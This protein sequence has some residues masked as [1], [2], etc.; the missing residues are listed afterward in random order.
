[1]LIN[2][3]YLN[4]LIAIGLLI[5]TSISVILIIVKQISC[6]NTTRWILSL[7]I[8]LIAILNLWLIIYGFLNYVKTKSKNK[9][10]I[11]EI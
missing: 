11:L 4:N 6:E 3:L 2:K 8:V 10:T 1:M 9:Q 7:V 5:I